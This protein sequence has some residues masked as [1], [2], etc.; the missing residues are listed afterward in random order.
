MSSLW[1]Q[2]ADP[3]GNPLDLLEQLVL[4]QEWP[5]HRQSEE[6]F[7]ADLPGR[8]ATYRLWSAWHGEIGVLHLSC[9]LDLRIDEDR[10][11]TVHTLLA[12]ANEKLWLGHFELWSEERMPVFRHSV[13]FRDGT[14]AGQELIE[15]LVDIAMGECDRFYPAFDFVRI[16]GRSPAEA[17]AAALLETEG[18]A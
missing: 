14:S 1:T 15:D 8:W 12:L 7:A 5:C 17:L 11:A 4:S 6:E 2:S 10:F 18:E 3:S 9:A 13:L 16:P